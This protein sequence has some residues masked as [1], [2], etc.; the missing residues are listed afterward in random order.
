MLVDPEQDPILARALVGTLRDEWRPAADAM[1]SARYWERR[2]YVL[3]S[4]ALLAARHLEWLRN[5]R[6]ARP[7]DRDAKAVECAIESLNGAG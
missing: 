4:L 6:R 7:D 1:A 2:A 5:W 3:L